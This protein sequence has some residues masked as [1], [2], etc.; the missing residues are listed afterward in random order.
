MNDRTVLYG[1][2]LVL[3]DAL[4]QFTDDVIDECA[5]KPGFVSIKGVLRC[6]RCQTVLSLK[7][8][9]PCICGKRCFYCREC[10]QLGKVR[11]CDELVTM[12]EPNQFSPVQKPCLKWNGTLSQQQKEASIEINASLAANEERIIW[13]VTGAGKT[14]MLF[15][16]IGQALDQ[17]KRVCI[18]SPRIDV[19]LELAPR[20]QRVFPGISSI[21]LYG[22][23]EEAYRYTQLVITTT[24]QLLRF[25]EAFD[26][27]VID[28]IDAFPF[29]LNTALYYAAEKARKRVSSV[30]YLTATPDKETQKKIKRGD[31]KASILPA[32]YHKHPLPVPRAVYSKTT[33]TDGSI[34]KSTV[35]NHICR[36]IDL[37]KPFLVFI[38]TISLMEEVA[39][40][41]KT[42][43]K[44]SQFEWVHSKDT[45][46]KEKVMKMRRKELD[47]LL[48]T[49]I[50]ERG[51]TFE[52]IDVIVLKADHEV[53][54]EA[55][56]V[57]IAGRAGRSVAYPDGEV[58]FYHQGWTRTIKRAISQ[59]KYMN[60]LGKDKGLLI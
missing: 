54:T 29:Y 17:G 10:I 21:L 59:I 37:K 14:E 22:G 40:L 4:A 16:G 52:N 39:P 23:S 47:F 20:L 8:P 9:Y 49:T 34:G 42:I 56:L 28:E 44:E 35:F 26:V 11:A 33:L 58:T 38:P 6:N 30:I 41:F 32:R 48:T 25:N 13:A 46:R 53:Y 55:A 27:L 7:Q 19:C 36:L 24:H 3:R 1:R 31:I 57:Q 45:D 15:Y 18:A 60:K 2:E 43:F 51:V 50:L 12:T 5:K